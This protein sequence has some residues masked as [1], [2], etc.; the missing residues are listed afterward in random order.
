MCFCL[1][2][3]Q[4]FAQNRVLTGKVTDSK[5]NPIAHASVLVK[6]TTVGT[7]TT[8]TGNFSFSVPTTAK[9][10][11]ISSVNFENYELTI[12][13]KNDFSVALKES[14]ILMDEVFVV[15][16]GVSKREAF[17]GS[18]ATV[19]GDKIADLRPTSF[20]KALQ[21]NAA[22]VTSLSNSGQPGAGQK[23]VI[24]GIG[25]IS[26]GTDPLYV[27]DGVP[28]ASGNFGNM[29]ATAGTIASDNMN[30]LSSINPNDIETLIVLK[31]ASA[32][33]IYGARASN[34]VI[35]ITTKKGKSGK[36]QFSLNA[37]TGFSDK[38]TDNFKVLNR[39]EYITYLSQARAN[40][41]YNDGTTIV[42]GKP[43]N[44][45]IAKTFFM[46]D[47]SGNFYDFDWQSHAYN[48]NATTNAVDISAAGGNDKTKFFASAS[49]FDQNGIVISTYMKRASFRLNLDHKVSD[50]FQLSTNLNLSYTKQRSPYTTSSYYTNPVFA[51]GFYSPL[52]PGLLPDGTPNIDSIVT[53]SNANFLANNAYNDFSTNTYR[54]LGNMSAQWNISKNFI[55]KSVVG[56][57]LMFIPEYEWLDPR[58]RGNSASYLRGT[59]ES[60]I[61]QNFIW[62]ETT[63]LN[64]IKRFGNSNLNLMIGQE[65]Q[66]SDK[67]ITDA[68]KQDFPGIDFHELSSGATPYSTTGSRTQ[69]SLSS[70][71]A[72]AN[73]EFNNKYNISGSV[74]N[75]ASSKFAK[76]NRNAQFW[77]VGALWKITKEEFTKDIKWLNSLQLRSSFG[78]SGNSSG[79]GNYAAKGLYS[80]GY[81]YNGDPGVAPYQIKNDN[82]RWERNESFNVGLDFAVLNNRISGTVEYYIKTTKDLLLNANL[83]SVSGFT[84]IVSNIGSM[85]NKGIE[86]TLR[87]QPVVTKNFS[88]F[89]DVNA[90]SNQNRILKLY[91][92]QDI[93]NSDLS[94]NIYREGQDIQSFYL[95]PWAGVNPADGR[96][97]YYDQKGE[98]IY[99]IDQAGDNR[100][101][102]GS[103]APK[104]YGGITNTFRYKNFELTAMLYYTVGNKIYDQS[105]LTYTSMGYRGLYNQSKDILTDAW[106]K[107]GDISSLPKAYYGYAANVFGGYSMDKL[108]FDGSYLRLRD[109]T[110]A[111]NL[112]E[113][114]M[115]AI[116][117][118]SC[119]LYVQGS[120]LFTVTKFPDADPEAG[121][122]GYYSYGYPNMRTFTL[123]ANIKF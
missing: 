117:F 82:L 45:F 100:K 79:I 71:F 27:I 96:P 31:D 123:G 29:T 67:R 24:R 50:K 62:N 101:I 61:V 73:Y 118:S 93:Y 95:R 57:D 83:S 92:G 19:K 69:F 58:P 54:A 103:A 90:T 94:L 16:Y 22:G 76:G 11:V 38:T 9:T 59:S 44:S 68:I 72:S 30:A 13:S 88:W 65:V 122:S 119:R 34:G 35:L 4:L 7:K 40:A 104:V 21:G 85:R 115:K 63:T 81:N 37:S 8:E 43:V 111:Y 14:S 60:S 12:G 55:L 5:G 107:E 25:S 36:T 47:A 49:Y 42:N 105:L 97:M 3:S 46:R 1:A 84:S 10:L 116:K 74:R 80:G 112:P 98:I 70:F 26:A 28:L 53:Y 86:I 2:L 48:N 18:I 99:Q 77:S 32:T 120:N 106:Q 78:T 113:K 114:W 6:G 39:D 108:L 75:D 20:D 15:G 109:L 52:D 121:L 41:G 102:A 51:S 110:F 91:N 23:V 56:M 33:S 66:S 17:T 64:Y 89:L 87:T